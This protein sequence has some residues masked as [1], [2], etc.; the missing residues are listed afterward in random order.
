M[1]LISLF[2]VFTLFLFFG[3]KKGDSPVPPPSTPPSFALSSL[4]VNGSS[5]GFTYNNL[6]LTPQIR[7]SFGAPVQIQS[8]QT[9]ITFQTSAG[10]PV[11]FGSSFQN[12]DSTIIIQPSVPLQSLSRYVVVVSTALQSKGGGNL[13]TAITIN[14]TT[15]IDSTDKFPRISD[16][17]LLSLVQ[18]QTL[19]YFTNFGHPVSGLARERNTSGDVVTTGGTGFGVMAM[20]AGA[21][22]GFISRA[23]ALNRI[24]TIANWYK[25][26]CTAYHGAFAHWIN[27]ATGATVPFS[28]QDDGADLVETSYLMQGLLCA[29]QYFSLNNSTETAL[30]ETINQLW[31]AVEWTWFQQN[32]QN[33]LY[34]HWSPNNGWA[35]NQKIEGWNEAL[36]VY[37]LAASSPTHPIQ[38][39]V[40]DE[41]WARV[42]AIKNGKLF[43]NITLL[44][45]ED[46]GGPLFFSHYSFL[47]INPHN[48]TDN[49]GDYWQQNTAHTNIN[50]SYCAANPKGF[51]GYSNQCWGLTASDEQNGYSAHSPTADNGTISPTAA[52]SSMP[53]DTA[54]SMAAL[55]F[56]Y[57]KLGDKLWGDYGFKDAFNLSNNWFADSYLAIDQGPEIVM[58]ENMRTGLLWKL[59]MSCPE[60]KQGMKNLSFQSPDL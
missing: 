10:T 22:R 29:R 27:G 14:L 45:G 16:D 15:A 40:Y 58:I 30:R 54:K 38:K 6:T 51:V 44:L 42:G 13:Q 57:Y 32:N 24:A 43:Y 50:Y 35:I 59:F 20:I 47:G 39:A 37:A 55:R 23:D 60:V 34:W 53:Y 18:K 1:K 7:L 4:Q 41:G 36:I 12:N 26:K 19:N 48:L 49:Y 2:F 33:V 56:F 3:C 31:N 52:I 46:Y 9:A 17:S 11:A 5:S 21:K 8:A 25:N 28:A